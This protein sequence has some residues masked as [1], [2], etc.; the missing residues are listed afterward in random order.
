MIHTLWKS[1]WIG[2]DG[3]EPAAYAV[4]RRSALRLTWPLPVPVHGLFL[5]SLRKD[6]LYYRPTSYRDRMDTSVLVGPGEGVMWD[7]ISDAPMSTEFAISRFLAPHL[8]KKG[9]ALFM[10]SDVLVRERLDDLWK[11]CDPNKAVMVVKHQYEP[12]EGEKMD[13]QTQLRYARK[14]WSSVMI[15]NCEHKANKALTVEYVNSVPG[16]DLHRF[17][18]LDDNEIGELPPEWNWLVGHSDTN[19]EPKIVH[20]TEGGP[21]FKGYENV[22]YA[23]EWR[24]ELARWV[25]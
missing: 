21:W 20:F 23:D 8:A 5:D 22:P 10:D 1:I 19:L 18:W 14:N 7:D 12:P 2:Y 4:A 11:Q 25:L 9:L 24:D 16:R 6:G 13:G 3:R 17:A 15:F